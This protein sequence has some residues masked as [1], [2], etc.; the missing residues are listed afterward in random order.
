[1][2]E[3]VETSAQVERLRRMGVDFVQGFF[4][5]RAVDAKAA[6][7]FVARER[8]VLDG[9]SRPEPLRTQRRAGRRLVA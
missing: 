6:E 9:S 7:A 5:S 2:A 8:E 3:G 1:V 4:F